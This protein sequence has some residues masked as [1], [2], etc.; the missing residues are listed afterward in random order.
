MES[1][2]KERKNIK[3]IFSESNITD[4]KIVI[5]ND[6]ITLIPNYWNY[7]L[8]TNFPLL[9]IVIYVLK[10]QTDSQ[11]ILLGILAIII[12]IYNILNKLA[13]LNLLII[14]IQNKTITIIP[15][16]VTMIWKKK[17][18][19]EYKNIRNINYAPDT[20]SPLYRRFV[21]KIILK[22]SQKINL[23]SAREEKDADK[24]LKILLTYF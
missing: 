24:L 14:N 3:T 4:P 16:Y 20:F 13:S 10:N 6:R 1:S 15:N 22:N 2:N 11:V 9:I 23:I 12:F 7:T 8:I 17:E 5:T 19:V 21:I 18:I